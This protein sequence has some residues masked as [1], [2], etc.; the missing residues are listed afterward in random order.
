MDADFWHQR[1]QADNIAF[2][3]GR[4][5]GY[6]KTYF[7][8][9]G[10]QPDDTV[11]VPLC[12]KAVDMSWIRQQQRRVLGI[13]LSPIAIKDF[14]AEQE[15]DF[16]TGEA[17]R[18]DKFSGDGID[19]LCGDLFDM[20]PQM[21]S[22]VR[23]VYDRASYIASDYNGR[24]RYAEFMCANLPVGARILLLTLDYPQSIM[25]GPPFA[26]DEAE[27]RGRFENRYRVEHLETRD[28]I[29]KQ[30]RFQQKGLPFLLAHAFLLNDS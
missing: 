2:H 24:K 25:E 20:T 14:F 7:E 27:V 16:V 23:G 9:I 22:Q 15:I 1:W 8:R 18:F 17:G 12:G 10:T 4:V 3:E 6:L 26:V 5:N 13:E 11:F 30:P 28:I 29:E 19:L 21:L